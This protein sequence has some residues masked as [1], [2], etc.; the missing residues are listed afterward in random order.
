M[1]KQYGF[2]KKNNLFLYGLIGIL[3][4][5]IVIGVL[6]GCGKLN[7][8]SGQ[9]STP[10]GT[11]GYSPIPYGPKSTAG[12]FT[13]S[14]KA[15]PESVPADA[16]NYSTITVTLSNTSGL[17]VSGYTIKY[18]AD[19]LY[20]WF[21]EPDSG[22]FVSEAEGVTDQNGVATK[23]FYGMRSGQ[24][25]VRA[26]IDVD[27]DSTADLVVSKP[28]TFTPGGKPS[29]AWPYTLELSASPSSIYANL[30]DYSTIIA[31]LKDAS[32]GSVEN[33][34]IE[35]TSELG[36]LSNNPVPPTRDAAST[37]ATAL[38]NKNGSVS[39]YYYADRAGSAVI[40]ATVSVRDLMTSLQA[41]T[42][43][44]V[45]P[46]PGKPGN[47]VAG[48]LVDVKP[49]INY[50]PADI[51][52][53]RSTEIVT[54]NISG[55]V[56]DATGD[57]AL[58]GVR[59]EFSGACNGFATTTTDAKNRG[60][61]G[62][63]DP[64]VCGL[65]TLSIGTHAATITACTYSIVPQQVQYCDTDTAYII[66]TETPPEATPTPAATTTPAANYTLTVN[67][68]GSG[69]VTSAPTGISCG[70]DCSETFTASTSVTLT[71]TAASG[72]SFS[73]WSGACTGTVPLCTVTV[74]AATTVN[75]VF[76]T[77]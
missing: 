3:G 56:W 14:M 1:K 37:T 2:I 74:S 51:K 24:G 4:I 62:K 76:T 35:F 31:T 60:V 9:S 58:A 6:A 19:K 13:L 71:A 50:V 21:Y 16:T 29:S 18:T 39:L 32:G 44:H 41:K 12:T 45:L 40:S 72:S 65:G 73:A 43:I 30:G 57:E 47:D 23:R 70:T 25:V 67:K 22:M 26:E 38:T 64:I 49:D 17:P 63:E 59:V 53:G 8:D 28:V 52:T 46:G 33:F 48:I 61:F 10:S 68:T 27:E 75:A 20:G 11:S 55:N 77:P 42:V 66:V 34:T 69:T 54:I 15:D 5:G 7:D 36:Y